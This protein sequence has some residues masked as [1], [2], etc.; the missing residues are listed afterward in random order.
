MSIFGIKGKKKNIKRLRMN[1]IKQSVEYPDMS[2]L[3]HPTNS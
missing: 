1:D 3:L 2:F